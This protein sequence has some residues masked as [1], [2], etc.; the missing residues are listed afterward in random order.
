MGKM[1]KSENVLVQYSDDK[2]L[3]IRRNLHDKHST[4]K[5][6]IT[7]WMFENYEFKNGCRILEIG[8]GNGAQWAEGIFNLP[9]RYTMILS[10]LSRGMVDKVGEKYSKYENVIVQRIDIQDIPF[11]NETFDV[12]IANHMLY[13]VPDLDKAL[14]EIQRVLKADGTFYA[15]T[16]G[17]CGMR[18][19]LREAL[20]RLNPKL[21]TFKSELTFATQNGAQLLSEYFEE[22]KLVDYEDSLK[23]TETQD[24]VDWVKS[25]ITMASYTENDLDGLFEFFEEIRIRDG[26]INIPKEMGMF[27]SRKNK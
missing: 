4:N 25:T 8:C 22:V 15:T 16:N 3:S 24:L 13:H 23:V 10:D 12:I 21:D 17:N 9:E 27:I 1:N 11:A 2:N 14:S 20:K 26:A 19:Y 7:P 6:G 18:L 5:K